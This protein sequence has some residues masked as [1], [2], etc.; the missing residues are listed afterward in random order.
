M[1]PTV[2]SLTY[3]HPEFR[4][5]ARRIELF[6]ITKPTLLPSQLRCLIEYRPTHLPALHMA[7]TYPP[8]RFACTYRSV[9][10]FGFLPYHVQR[11]GRLVKLSWSPFVHRTVE[12]FYDWVRELLKT[13]RPRLNPLPNTFVAPLALASS[14]DILSVASSLNLTISPIVWATV[15]TSS[16]NAAS[17][18]HR[19]RYP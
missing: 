16:I 15:E 19:G 17:D 12:S 14:C 5:A 8:Q 2:G 10:F 7:S 4:L 9:L 18:P 3:G 13:S 1:T 11:I 6:G